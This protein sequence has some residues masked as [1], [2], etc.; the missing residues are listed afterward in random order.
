VIL[1]CNIFVNRIQIFNSPQSFS[2]T[3]IP[4]RS[5]LN[6]ERYGPELDDDTHITW[7][8]RLNGNKGI[9]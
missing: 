4:S 8:I 5:Q 7:K 3:V 1:K 6:W 9:C 2:R